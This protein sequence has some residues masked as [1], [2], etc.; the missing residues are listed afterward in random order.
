MSTQEQARK[1]MVEERQHEETLEEKMLTR[2]VEEVE[3]NMPKEIEEKARELIVQ[4]RLHG[5]EI[6]EKMLTRANEEIQ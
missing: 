4:E 2:A 1:L 6:E 3:T 5:E